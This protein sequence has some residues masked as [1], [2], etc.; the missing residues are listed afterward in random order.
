MDP[1]APLPSLDGGNGGIIVSPEESLLPRAC[2]QSRHHPGHPGHDCLPVPVTNE[3]TVPAP[4]RGDQSSEGGQSDTRTS[5][6]HHTTG[7][8]HATGIGDRRVAG[9]SI[10]MLPKSRV[11]SGRASGPG[12]S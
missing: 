10:M 2:C 8:H 1:K 6:G 4:A 9:E 11:A 12:R 3:C 5:G 7:Q